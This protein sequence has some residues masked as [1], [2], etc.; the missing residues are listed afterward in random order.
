MPRFPPLCRLF[1]ALAAAALLAG[2]PSPANAQSPTIGRTYV[3]ASVLADIKRFSG[4]PTEPLL[5]GESVGGG[6][7]IGTGLLPRWDIQVG[8]DVPRFTATSRDRS[9]TLQRSTYI[10]Q[11]VTENRGVSVAT[12]VRFRGASRGRVQLGYLGG[13]SLVRLRR[14]AHTVATED[15]PAGL[16]PKPDS[17]VDYTAAP[18][19]GIDARIR[20]AQHLSVVP[21]LQATVFRLSNANGLLL[22]PR[23]SF[24][25]SF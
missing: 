9:V 10:L 19:I 14:D 7:T 22:R 25:W 12:L 2:V 21:G 8:V 13:L 1:P 16:I 17:S 4:D 18:T 20:V 6:V 15:T 11:S 23:L 5:D 3:S 24:R